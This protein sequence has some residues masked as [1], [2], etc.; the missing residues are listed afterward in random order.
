MLHKDC[1]L[2]TA[3]LR[4]LKE[5]GWIYVMDAMKMVDPINLWT[6]AV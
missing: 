3:L 2:L 1:C 6:T 4:L 5:T